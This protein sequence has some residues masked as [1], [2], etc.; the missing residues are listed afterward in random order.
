ME[1][2]NLLIYMVAKLEKSR[3]IVFFFKK[4]ICF[5]DF[6]N[7]ISKTKRIRNWL[8]GFPCSVRIP[9]SVN[10]KERKM[11][12]FD[13]KMSRKWSTQSNGQLV[14]ALLTPAVKK[15]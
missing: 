9:H 15:E 14:K 8:Q 13:I 5:N 2:I 3:E 6:K 1:K 11:K 10:K 12:I 7:Q 4:L